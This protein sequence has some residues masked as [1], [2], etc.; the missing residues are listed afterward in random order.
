MKPID[1]LHP[2]LAAVVARFPTHDVDETTLAADRAART[3]IRRATRS[4]DRVDHLVPGDPPVP[5]RL[6]RPL[7]T[8]G[9]MPC[10]LTIHGG[11]YVQGNADQDDVVWDDVCLDIGFT[12]LSV[13]YRLAPETPYPGA[14]EDCYAALRWGHDNAEELGIDATRIGLAG[15]SAGGGLVAA[16]A[17]LTRDRGEVAVAFQ[18][19]DSPMLDDRRTPSNGQDDLPVSTR[20]SREFAWRSYLGDLHGRDEV[21]YTAAPA[22]AAVSDLAGLPPAFVAVGA[23][24]GFVDEAVT[25]AQRLNQAGVETELHVYPGLCHGYQMA[26]QIEPVRRA[27]RDR[28]DWL[29]VQLRE[30]EPTG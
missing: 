14:L 28:D 20:R 16:L 12:R 4:A 3:A 8:D 11:G 9:P 23:V 13:D 29:R 19:L 2:D 26:P 6:H 25:Y 18:L 7:G 30:K 21:P 5:V 24:D 1:R 17:L 15:G 27:F 22:R 10:L